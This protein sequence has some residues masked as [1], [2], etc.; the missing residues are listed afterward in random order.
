MSLK[1]AEL[2]CSILKSDKDYGWNIKTKLQQRLC[3]I[4]V[5]I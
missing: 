2:V 4:L 3:D 1:A 5:I